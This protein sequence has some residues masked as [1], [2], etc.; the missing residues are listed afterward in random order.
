MQVPLPSEEISGFN[1]VVLDM[2]G[3]YKKVFDG[4]P[5]AI[6]VR[7]FAVQP[8]NPDSSQFRVPYWLWNYREW[9]SFTE[10]SSGVQAPQLRRCLEDLRSRGYRVHAREP[11]APVLARIFLDA[12]FRSRLEMTNSYTNLT[13]RPKR[14]AAVATYIRSWRD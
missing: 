3:E 9:L 5:P 4:L 8:N 7:H 12:T 10:A 2:S 14:R 11:R 13:K 1:A 6:A